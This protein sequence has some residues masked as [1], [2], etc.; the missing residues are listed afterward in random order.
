LWNP[1]FLSSDSDNISVTL[2]LLF[3]NYSYIVVR[4]CLVKVNDQA[5]A[6]AVGFFV[7]LPSIAMDW[8]K[9]GRISLI[10]IDEKF[11]SWKS[12][13]HKSGRQN[14]RTH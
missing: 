6:P 13:S 4:Y 12:L 10:S 1:H 9:T 3:M 7:N 5:L 14:N 11:V 8:T 2:D